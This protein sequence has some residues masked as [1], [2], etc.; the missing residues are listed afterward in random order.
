MRE[1]ERRHADLNTVL[2][3]Q[4]SLYRDQRDVTGA[5]NR[6]TVYSTII[7]PCILLHKYRFVYFIDNSIFFEKTS[8]GCLLVGFNS[9]ITL[10]FK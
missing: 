3:I 5:M 10:L 1:R 4:R 7:F 6:Y 8:D 9:V 2:G